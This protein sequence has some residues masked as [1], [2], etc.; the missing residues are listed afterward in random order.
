[1]IISTLLTLCIHSAKKRCWMSVE[2]WEI[3]VICLTFFLGQKCII[4]PEKTSKITTSLTKD[5]YSHVAKAVK[6]IQKHLHSADCAFVCVLSDAK[7]CFYL[8]RR[9]LL[10][11]EK[12]RGDEGRGE[13]CPSS[14]HPIQGWV[15]CW[16]DMLLS[17]SPNVMEPPMVSRKTVEII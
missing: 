9:K 10:L 17:A 12:I 14:H 8:F 11:L 15:V 4:L 16:D 1:M 7:H 3:N 13:E 2:S 6:L 5:L